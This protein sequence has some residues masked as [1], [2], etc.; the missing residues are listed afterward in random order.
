VFVRLDGTR[1][2]LECTEDHLIWAFGVICVRRVG[3]AFHSLRAL[4]ATVD[5]GST[6]VLQLEN[7]EK[8]IV[9]LQ[10]VISLGYVN[11]QDALGFDYRHALVPILKQHIQVRKAQPSSS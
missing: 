9:E 4:F 1:H 5:V 8:R 2:P 10:R 11:L 7:I 6:I 3:P